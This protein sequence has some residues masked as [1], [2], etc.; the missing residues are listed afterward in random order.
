[1]SRWRCHSAA[2]LCWLPS[3]LAAPTEPL[4]EVGDLRGGAVRV[5][6]AWRRVSRMV[7]VTG[8]WLSA[9][10]STYRL[11]LWCVLVWVA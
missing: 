9:V 11:M 6:W 3:P 1:M 8:V 4:A 7:A 10:C 5:E 2:P